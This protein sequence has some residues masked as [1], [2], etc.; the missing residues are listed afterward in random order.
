MMKKM[1]KAGVI[2]IGFIGEE[3]IEAIGRT[4]LAQVTAIAG[5]DLEKTGQK[6][7]KYGIATYYGDYK[8]LLAEPEIDVVHICS[9]NVCHYPMAKEALLA[10]KHVICEKPLTV[11]REE[12]LELMTL[13]KE[14]GLVNAIHF[15]IRYYPLVR[16]A[17]EMIA[18]QEL[19]SLYAVTGSYLQDWLLYDT[20]YSWRLE[21]QQSGPTR[22]VGDIGTHWMDLAEYVT[23]LRIASVMA[24]TAT[25]L[26]TRK[27]PRKAMETWSGKVLRSQDYQEV[28]IDTEDYATV[29]LRFE[30]GSRGVFT[31][32]QM[33]SGRKNRVY[34]EVNGAKSSVMWNSEAPNELMIGNRD[35]ANGVLIK[36]PSL[37]HP[38]VRDIIS[39]PGGHNEGFPDTSKQLFTQVYRAILEGGGGEP[40]FPTFAQG[41]REA[42]LCDAIVKSATERR[43]VDLGELK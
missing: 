24:D 12:A 3:H 4:F 11:S 23:G 20:D 29:M 31:V 36:D 43:W 1:L 13:A 22:A 8:K 10:G 30:N 26:P 17:R 40:E 19:G 37:V 34:L 9:P 35:T 14:R 21:S 18:R 16:Q 32:N 7:E 42:L 33:A 41:Y 5:R 39:L 27:K 15:N 25:F 2:G 6:A 28:P 38:P